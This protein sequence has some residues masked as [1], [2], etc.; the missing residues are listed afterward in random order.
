MRA[1]SQRVRGQAPPRPI[2]VAAGARSAPAI[3]IASA[4]RSVYRVH[5]RSSRHLRA[6]VIAL[7]IVL[8]ACTHTEWQAELHVPSDSGRLDAHA[9]F[10]KV[11]MDD[12]EVY[13]LSDWRV[14]QNPHVV[15]GVGLHYDAERRVLGEGLQ[16]IPLDRVA[17]LETNRPRSVFHAGVAVLGVATALSLA[18]NVACATNP[19]M[20]YGSCP[21]FYAEDGAGLA[22]QAEGFSGSFARALE[23][24][25]VDALRTAR[26]VD[27][28]VSIVMRDEAAETHVVRSVRL[29]AIPRPAGRRI[30][31]S[32]G[33]FFAAGTPIAPLR[34]TAPD[35]D[36]TADV[37]QGDGQEDTTPA[38]PHDL[39]TTET[40]T[41]SFGPSTGRR[42]LIVS[43]RNSLVG[44]F[45]FYQVLAW[46]GHD[47]GTLLTSL[48]HE[49][50]GASP[51]RDALTFGRALAQ[52]RVEVRAPGGEWMAAGTY[53]EF[54]P[55][56][57][58][59]Q[60][61]PLPEGLADGPLEVRLVSTRGFWKID[62]LAL[63]QL[64]PVS[65]PTPIEP[66]RVLHHDLEDADALARLRDPERYLYTFPGDAYTLDYD[67]PEDGDYELFLE[68]RGYYVEWIRE[69][70]L[71]EQNPVEAA[72]FL[73][74][75]RA[76]LK[77]LAPAYARTAPFVEEQ[78]SR[79]RVGESRR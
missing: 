59:L 74:D 25:D 53:E 38:D 20:C 68:S 5:M 67:V 17:L 69:Q 57:R 41:L 73:L 43:A 77:R 22:L 66:T 2:A 10:L 78:F 16:A 75:P 54:G 58:D 52:L 4:R 9:P 31:R 70:W 18:V 28:H 62:E 24:T 35:R 63:V 15:S 51:V 8:S 71:T 50:A 55:I 29:L 23:D 6:R 33:S 76:A 72:R 37:A 45:V 79:T 32:G 47:A 64:E 3:T 39:A 65:A 7:T 49:A 13:V 60:V 11:H 21:T 14:L 56:A 27:G 12:G 36:C 44:T 48:D 46:L 34:C 61:V 40:I 1:G 42:G 26:S 30:V 19:K